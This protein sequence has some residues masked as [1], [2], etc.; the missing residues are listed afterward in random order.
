MTTDN[1]T[2][3]AG[4]GF[5]E[6]DAVGPRPAEA[7]EAAPEGLSAPPVS[8]PH[9]A[10]LAR[11][12]ED[13]LSN[14]VLGSPA[15]ITHAVVAVL[16]GGHLLIEDVPGVGKTVLAK[17]LAR[18]IGGRLARIQGHPDL[19]PSDITGITVYS[20]ATNSWEFRA[21]PVFA[22]VVLVDELNRTPPR[23]QAALLE[24]ME[25]GQVSV[26]GRSWR[27][28]RPHLVIATQNPIGHAGTYPLVESQMD[29]FLLATHLGYPDEATETL[30][31]VGHGVESALRDL[32][33]VTSPGELFA[34]QAAIGGVLVSSAVA[35]YAVAVVRATRSAPAVELGASPRG[36][37]VARRRQGARRAAR[38]RLRDAP[39]REVRRTRLP[40]PPPRPGSRRLAGRPRCEPDRR[41]SRG[42]AAA[43]RAGSCP[44][45]VIGGRAVGSGSRRRSGRAK[46]RLPRPVRGGRAVLV[47]GLV[48]ALW[49][50][51]AHQ[52][53]SGW[54]QAVGAV[55]AA[56]V[57]VGLVGPA[58]ATAMLSCSLGP[59]PADA[60][61]GDELRVPVRVDRAARV[62]PIEP[63]G[64]PVVLAAGQSGEVVLLPAHRGMIGRVVVEV[65][66]A[67]PFGLLWWTRREQFDL[68]RP[69]H[70]APRMLA[71][72]PAGELV[73]RGDAGGRASVAPTGEL[74][75]TRPY[76][77]G[78]DRRR[79][80][81]PVSAH[82][83][84]LMVAEH[85]DGARRA[86][87]VL[88]AEL[89]ADDDEAEERAGRLLGSVVEL[90]GRGR[91]VV[92]QTDEPGGQVVGAV[93]G[94]RQA[95]RRLARA[96]HPGS[97]SSSTSRSPDRSPAGSAPGSPPGLPQRSAP[98]RLR[99]LVGRR[100][101][102]SPP[103]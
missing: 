48:L 6:R 31:A 9:A 50:A 64:S 85:E 57:A 43:A 28:P 72:L 26:D 33:P 41:R 61:A 35:S 93:D 88:R 38:S 82:A 46:R 10:E 70:V 4:S 22:D 19:L 103:A 89:P 7:P 24:T 68:A 58:A 29:R 83:A 53:G 42:G 36:D 96:V 5:D 67:W 40:R 39:R 51:V 13:S 23:S 25:E 97:H 80:H 79:V 16:A 69:V 54:V 84:E 3:D 49:A 52:S 91:P 95:G 92:L 94:P 21:G 8:V 27:L 47:T 14:V 44:A 101:A 45:A 65:A 15:A 99:S 34:A 86:P 30:L 63:A 2:L 76:R 75:G 55:V 20:A 87:V 18:V 59:V 11:R 73:G 71:P 1:S 66:S 98:S 60:T 62:T 74:R 37:R 102:T 77:P 56:V 100:R 81:W 90:L 78:D 17:A 12:L 32:T